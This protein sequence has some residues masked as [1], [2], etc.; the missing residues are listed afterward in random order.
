MQ[1]GKH[2]LW[3]LHPGAYQYLRNQL[4]TISS[5]PH[6]SFSSLCSLW[7]KPKTM[8]IV[9]FQNNS[10]IA[11]WNL[12][13]WITTTISVLQQPADYHQSENMECIS[14]LASAVCYRQGFQTKVTFTLM[15]LTASFRHNCDGAGQSFPVRP[16]LGSGNNL[17]V[18]QEVTTVVRKFS[19]FG[20]VQ[21]RRHRSKF[22]EVLFW[23]VL[24]TCNN[25]IITHNIPVMIWQQ[26]T[27]CSCHS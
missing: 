4:Q 15:F 18:L 22:L 7:I 13:K 1:S 12:S 2:F 26:I 6:L 17:E 10:L 9:S 25:F 16:H 14:L 19:C 5:F 21:I 8:L 3:V 20:N 24:H 11:L 27:L 23:N